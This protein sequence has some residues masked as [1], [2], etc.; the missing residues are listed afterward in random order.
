MNFGLYDKDPY[1]MSSP[2]TSSLPHLV[3][4]FLGLPPLYSSEVSGR[5]ILSTV[6]H[7]L[8]WGTH[9]SSPALLYQPR[10]LQSALYPHVKVIFL[11]HKS[12]C[13]TCLKIFQVFSLA[14]KNPNFF[15]LF[16]SLF[17]KEKLCIFK[18]HVIWN[19]YTEWNDYYSQ[20]N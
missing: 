15:V 4:R 3:P 9:S 8:G 20:A 13:V 17:L 5:T 12:N 16:I 6:F 2:H 11:K 19:T 7:V 10:S 1:N 18:V 14:D